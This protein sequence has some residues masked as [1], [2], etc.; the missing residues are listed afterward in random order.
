MAFRLRPHDAR[1]GDLLAALSGHLGD[2]AQLLAEM[3]GGDPEEQQATAQR[4]LDVDQDAEAAAHA[5]L[6]ALSAAFVTPFDRVDIYRV[7]W[8]MRMC[9]ARMSAVADEIVLFEIVE[10][11]AGVTDLVQLV[12]RAAEVTMQAVPRLGR[13][14][15]LVDP[16]IELTRLGKQAGQAHRRLLADITSTAKEPAELVRL[17]A[18]A[19]SLLR[20]VNSFEEVAHA[21]QTVSVKEG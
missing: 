5:V 11:P 12:V 7:A 6:R 14:R 18:L 10:P 17:T 2:G 20:V 1:F 3:L 21:F 16:W 15:L 13:P 4:L 9:T 19:Q 8:S